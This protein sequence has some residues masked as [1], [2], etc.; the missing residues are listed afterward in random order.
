[1]PFDSY[2]TI[3]LA[4]VERVTLPKVAVNVS[5]YVPL[6]A[7][8][9]IVTVAFDVAVGP[10]TLT[11]FGDTAHVLFGGPPMHPRNTGPFKP[12]TAVTVI[13]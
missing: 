12:F 5:T 10:E 2:L 4:V 8:A 1:M 13:A 6:L 11:G 3:R 9:G 7:P